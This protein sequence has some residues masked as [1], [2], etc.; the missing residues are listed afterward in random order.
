MSTVILPRVLRFKATFNIIYK[1]EKASWEKEISFDSVSVTLQYLPR[2][3]R[4]LNSLLKFEQVQLTPQ[5]C[6]AVTIQSAH[7]TICI[8]ILA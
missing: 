8:A 6:M 2:V 5:C 1:C 3:F 7:D 4:H